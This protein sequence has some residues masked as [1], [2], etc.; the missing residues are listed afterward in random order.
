MIAQSSA[1]KTALFG[2]KDPIENLRHYQASSISVSFRQIDI[3]KKQATKRIATASGRIKLRQGTI[4]RIRKGLI[5]KGDPMSLA[6]I[7]G[8]MAAKRTSELLPLCH[9]LKIDSTTIETSLSPSGI[10]VT[11]T[12]SATEKTGLEM[13]ALTATTVALLNIW[14]VV[15]TYEKDSRG[16]YPTTR[17]QDVRVVRKVK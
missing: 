13:E 4:R 14:D 10:E 11:T 12:V 5:E 2:I 3:S 7:S 1:K 9:P 8:I 17:I 16:Q 6:K 15:K